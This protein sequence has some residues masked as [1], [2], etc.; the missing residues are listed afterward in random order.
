M[1]N[2]YTPCGMVWYGVYGVVWCGMVCMWYGVVWCG[3]VWYGVVW[4]INSFLTVTGKF[5]KMIG[6]LPYLDRGSNKKSH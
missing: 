2:T 1:V 4:D 5:S 6:T 3:M